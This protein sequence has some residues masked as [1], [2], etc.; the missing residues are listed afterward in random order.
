[1]NE[2]RT[3]N[4]LLLIIA[5]PVVFYILKLLSFIFIPLVFSMFIALLFWPLVRWLR[6]KKTPKSISILIVILIISVFIKLTIEV[7]QISSQEILASENLI[8]KA[9]S[10]LEHLII[11]LENYLAISITPLFLE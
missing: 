8:E 9:E 2:R 11:P 6:N 5:V 4:I 10:K 3:T 1:M 7:I